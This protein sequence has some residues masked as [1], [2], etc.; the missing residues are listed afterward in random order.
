VECQPAVTVTDDV[1]T[2]PS[3]AAPRGLMKRGQRLWRDT[4][5][6]GPALT[7]GQRVTLEEACRCA[8]RLDRLHD[9]L[10]GD[11]DAWLRLKIGE[12]LD[13]E[14]AVTVMIDNTL[15]EARQ[16]QG[17]LTRLLSE[18]RQSRAATAG[19][20]SGAQPAEPTRREVPPG[21]ADFS[22]RLAEQLQG[23]KATP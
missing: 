20:S 7:A 19:G 12:G 8:D 14:I 16:Q 1:T 17:V 13:G 5:D 3:P 2:L 10:R 11:D 22:K 21:V 23:A 6:N 15:S 4:V 9:L 18:L